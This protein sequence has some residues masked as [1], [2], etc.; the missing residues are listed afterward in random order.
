MTLQNKY[1]RDTN[2]SVRLSR[3]EVDM[4]G[5]WRKLKNDPQAI[6]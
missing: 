5:S 4:L 3:H 2:F 6:L 1:V